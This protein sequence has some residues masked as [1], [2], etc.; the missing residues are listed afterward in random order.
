MSNGA[1]KDLL[2]INN[3]NNNNNK[4]KVIMHALIIRVLY[5]VRKNK[6]TNRLHKIYQGKI[7]NDWSSS[8]AQNWQK[9][10]SV[11]KF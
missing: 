3:N 4:I 11:G 6:M 9:G 7:I 5:F 8:H 2:H 10:H 1:W